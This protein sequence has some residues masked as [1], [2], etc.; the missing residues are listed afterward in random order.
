MLMR[1][2]R[3]FKTVDP[4]PVDPTSAAFA[5]DCPDRELV[6]EIHRRVMEWSESRHIPL[7][8][9]NAERIVSA[10]Y[11]DPKIVPRHGAD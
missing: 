7:P 11:H 4:A 8:P 5:A 1:W 9:A 10:L 3:R 6:V 2:L